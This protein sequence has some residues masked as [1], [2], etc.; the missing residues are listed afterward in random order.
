MG[1][2]LQFGEVINC[3]TDNAQRRI[4]TYRDNAWEMNKEVTY[5]RFL[6]VK[7]RQNCKH[8]W[9]ISQTATIF[10]SF[11]SFRA[12]ILALQYY[13]V[14][15]F[16]EFMPQILNFFQIV[17]CSVYIQEFSTANLTKINFLSWC[18]N[19]LLWTWS[20]SSNCK[21]VLNSKLNIYAVWLPMVLNVRQ[22]LVMQ[23]SNLQLK[24]VRQVSQRG[25]ECFSSKIYH[26]LKLQGDF[27][28]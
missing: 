20:K 14:V 6:G 11:F 12:C 21:Y 23:S 24:I 28:K 19:Y 13:G 5:W 8:N 15:T 3:T 16:Y 22:K 7:F 2:Q 27:H 1:E 4:S 25:K 10:L 26:R 17:S 18:T 9:K